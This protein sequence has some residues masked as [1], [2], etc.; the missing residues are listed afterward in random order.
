MSLAHIAVY[1][2]LGF[3]LFLKGPLKRITAGKARILQDPALL[4]ILNDSLGEV[5]FRMKGH[6]YNGIHI[7][8]RRLVDQ[9]LAGRIH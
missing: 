9:K 5:G 4:S 6:F 3:P 1:S 8:V 7:Y 2:F